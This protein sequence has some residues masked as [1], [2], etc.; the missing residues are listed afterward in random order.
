MFNLTI[1]SVII[2]INVF[3]L[4]A[5]AFFIFREKHIGNFLIGLSIIGLLI[6]EMGKL[7]LIFNFVLEDKVLSLG[8]FLTVLFWLAA[9][10]SF[11]PSKPFSLNKAILSPVFGLLCLG[12]FFVWWIKPFVVTG[13]L[14]SSVQLSKIAQYFF[15]LVVFSLTLA[16]SNLERALYFLKQK[17]IRLLFVSALFLLGPYIFLSTYAVLFSVVSAKF[18]AYSSITVLAGSIIL[19]FSRRAGFG[20]EQAKEAGSIQT[21]VS[22]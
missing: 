16:L 4:G 2:G 13:D 22:F 8:L 21:S 12:F 14:G 19:I 15:V 11:L 3:L 20:V 9:S 18:L 5:S 10:A 7:S 1:F 17:N 6:L